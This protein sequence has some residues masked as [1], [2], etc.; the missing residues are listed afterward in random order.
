MTPAE[1]RAAA[2]RATELLRAQAA[3]T[4]VTSFVVL[5]SDLLA[6][7]APA[8]RQYA[9]T[10]DEVQRLRTVLDG[11]LDA[12]QALLTQAESVSGEAGETVARLVAP[13]ADAA[14]AARGE[15]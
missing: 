4:P 7:L 11:L 2:D 10:Q 13:L 9:D 1:L 6:I 5:P 15:G 14:A 3:V 12:A 8:A